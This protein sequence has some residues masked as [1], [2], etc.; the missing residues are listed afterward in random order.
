M[1]HAVEQS[2]LSFSEL[3]VV[4]VTTGPG[5]DATRNADTIPVRAIDADRDTNINSATG[6]TYITIEAPLEATV[7]KETYFQ[8][9]PVHN[10]LLVSY[11]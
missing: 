4:A 11:R 3:D 5:T 8:R 2:G 10:S 1:E 7:H 6:G 9:I